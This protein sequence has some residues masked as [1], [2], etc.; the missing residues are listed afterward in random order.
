MLELT[1]GKALEGNI[2]TKDHYLYLY[3]DGSTVLYIGRST[4]PLQR[5]YE[6]I[7]KGDFHDTP[8]PLGKTIIDN[9]PHSLGWN[10][11]LLTIADCEPFVR[12]HRPEFHEW[13]LQQTKRRLAR[14]A[15]E[16]AEESLID[17]YQPCLNVAGNRTPHPLPENYRKPS[18]PPESDPSK[19]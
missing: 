5:L 3:R 17:Y 6:H 9:L 19:V 14:E 16:V 11:L 13:Y 15:T 7:G 1:V 18:P 4:A 10:L 8:S 2:D 12:Q